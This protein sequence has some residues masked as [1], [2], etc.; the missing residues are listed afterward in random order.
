MN[1]NQAREAA[2]RESENS[3]LIWIAWEDYSIQRIRVSE[4]SEY[5]QEAT[6]ADREIAIY[7][8][9]DEL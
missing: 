3:L 6:L 5:L 8:D 2:K 1:E 7:E 4:Y 9:G